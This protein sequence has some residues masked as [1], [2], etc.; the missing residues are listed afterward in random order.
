[1][2]NSIGIEVKYDKTICKA[3]EIRQNEVV[4]IMKKYYFWLERL[5]QMK[6]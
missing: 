5:L 3:T 2:E 4:A 6:A 1:M